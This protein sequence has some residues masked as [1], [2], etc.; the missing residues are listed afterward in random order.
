MGH[1]RCLGKGCWSERGRTTCGVRV[2]LPATAAAL[3]SPPRTPSPGLRETPHRALLCAAAPLGGCR[4]RCRRLRRPPQGRARPHRL[5][6]AGPQPR[7]WAVARGVRGQSER[8]GG[9]W[10]RCGHRGGGRAL[11]AASLP[12]ALLARQAHAAPRLPV[13]PPRSAA[14]AA[15]AAARPG[16]RPSCGRCGS[17]C[18]RCHSG[19]SCCR[20][21]RRPCLCPG[22]RQQQRQQR[23]QRRRHPCVAAAPRGTARGA[24]A[25]VPARPVALPGARRAC[26]RGRLRRSHSCPAGARW[27]GGG[28]GGCSS[29]ITRCSPAPPPSGVRGQVR[30]TGRRSPGSAGWARRR[31]RRSR[32]GHPGAGPAPLCD[33]GHCVALEPPRRGTRPRSGR[34]AQPEGAPR[35][36]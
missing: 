4:R 25:R 2:V 28:H 36:G 35:L 30:R 8:R 23:R 7:L 19:C 6:L 22:R 34:R 1:V 9:S 26:A 29:V 24:P 18:P 11:P 12:R 3:S 17:P 21:R 31:C 14:A 16:P 33:V 15:T 20:Y 27:L 13:Q 32:C 10:R 5:L